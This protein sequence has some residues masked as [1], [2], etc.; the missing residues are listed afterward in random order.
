VAQNAQVLSEASNEL[1]VGSRRMADDT[2][3]AATQAVAAAAAAEEISKSVRTIASNTDGMSESFKKI[4]LSAQNAATVATNAVGVAKSTNTAIV[5]LQKSSTEI[6]EVIK[7]ITTIAEQTNLLAL[8]ATI[9]AARAGESGK[10]F[11]VVASEVKDLARKT[12]IATEDISQ[13]IV[14]IRDDTR[15]AIETIGEIS[16]VIEKINDHQSSIVT[17]V[18]EQTAMTQEINQHLTEL[19]HGSAEIAENIN[20]VAQ[21]ARSATDGALETKKS[22]DELSRMASELRER[23][24]SQEKAPQHSNGTVPYATD[25]ASTLALA[26]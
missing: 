10:G 21:A 8:N 17:E 6:Y 2:E 1:A 18:K 24:E 7:V 4:E 9:E 11:A 26:E 22:S 3:R 15:R 20:A 25:L 13:K 14:T 12:A 16:A 5:K 23:F 19:A